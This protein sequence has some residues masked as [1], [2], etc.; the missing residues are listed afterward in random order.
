VINRLDCCEHTDS[1]IVE[2]QE[3]EFSPI[4]VADR[5]GA[6]SAPSPATDLPPDCKPKPD[7]ASTWALIE[8]S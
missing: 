8:T 4:L 1:Q 5:L 7:A 3:P 2:D 6:R